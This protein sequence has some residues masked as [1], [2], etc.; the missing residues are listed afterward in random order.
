[1]SSSEIAIW[2]AC[3]GIYACYFC[4][5]SFYSVY[6]RNIASFQ[7]AVFVL[8]S[9]SF[10]AC[11]SGLFEHFVPMFSKA[12]HSNLMMASGS[13][14]GIVSSIGL[15]RFLR[16]EQRDALIDYGSWVL[17]ALAAAQ[18]LG[19]A[20][21]DRR[22]A[23]E[24]VALC[25]VL[26]SLGAF[27]LAL[28]AWLQ[29]D[30]HAL[31][32]AIA[33]LALVFAMTGLYAHVLEILRNDLPLQASTALFAAMFVVISCH[34]LKLRY[35]EVLRMMGAL[36]MN[37][38]KDLLTQLLTGAALVRQVD[39]AVARARR[40]RKEMAVIYVEINNTGKLLQEFGAHG[41]EQ[42]IYG[43]AARVHLGAGGGATLVG[44]YSDNGFVVVLDSI[45][46]P[47]VLRTLGLRLAAT[48]RRPFIINPMSS[49]PA[50]FRAEIGLGVARISPGRE[51]RPRA[52]YNST[53]MGG[54]DS[55][56]LAQDV[57]HEAAEL[58]LA[59]RKFNSRAAITDA[60]S[61]QTIPLESARF[62]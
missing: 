35:A 25:W 61:R 5:A 9:G 24:F 17:V 16:A 59:A 2:S 53:Q 30:R 22:Q 19:L 54:F 48:V 34:A 49:N 39:D 10:V 50:E 14:T 12:S 62:K 46:H 57:L 7:T 44:R 52:D 36:S 28:R 20:W 40:N 31:P 37:R 8:L 55:F 47:G 51:T 15:R 21:P 42:V 4:L 58:A 43:M 6:T 41:L 26:T 27:W 60:Y 56:S 38:D 13:L 32:M 11:T 29:G 33:S 18:L 45:K 1:M 23:L 3:G